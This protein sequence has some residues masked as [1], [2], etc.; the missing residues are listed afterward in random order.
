MEDKEQRTEALTRIAEALERIA[1]AP[2]GA[3]DL[4]AANA[5]VWERSEAR[6]IAATEIAAPPLALLKGIDQNRD[7]LLDNTRQFARGHAANNVLLWGARG[8]GKSSLI[9]AV[10]VEVSKDEPH[11]LKLIEIHRDEI[12]SL[13]QL[14]RRLRNQEERCIFFCDDL[15]FETPDHHYKALKA[16]LEGGLEGRPANAL[17]YATSNRRHLVPRA[18]AENEDPTAIHRGE[19]AQETTSL[20]DR[21]GLS[22]GF[23]PASQEEYLA[24]VGAYAKHLGLNA[25]PKA[26]QK[27]AIA[28]AAGR[29]S[30]SG[31]VAWQF[32]Q[33]LAGRLGRR[34][35]FRG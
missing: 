20:A 12:D 16:V 15:S 13:P 3:L 8:A 5:F 24:M 22:L 31:R 17:F 4:Q 23:Y 1:P 21:F 26:I 14:L 9:K 2:L 29:G 30:R 10:C 28:W 33:D 35:D 32:I 6:L 18:M 11:P 25:D 19:T 34:I 7:L 27:Q